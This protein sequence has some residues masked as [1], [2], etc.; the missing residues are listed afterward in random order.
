MEALGVALAAV[1]L[2]ALYH[3]IRAGVRDGVKDALKERTVHVDGREP[4]R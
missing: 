2:Y 3:V 1:F 4:N